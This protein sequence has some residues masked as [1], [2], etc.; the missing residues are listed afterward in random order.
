MSGEFGS[1]DLGGYMHELVRYA[2][3]DC[4]QEAQGDTLTVLF[5]D[6][7]EALYPVARGISWYQ[8][9]DSG[10]SEPVVRLVEQ[11]PEI[12]RAVKVLEDHAAPYAEVA[13]RAVEAAVEARGAL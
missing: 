8:A 11:L 1:H 5:G 4:H 6:L 10:P 2:A 12:K 3:E 13:R 7:L 9:A